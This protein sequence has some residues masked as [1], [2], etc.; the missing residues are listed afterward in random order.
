MSKPIFNLYNKDTE[1]HLLVCGDLSV[2]HASVLKDLLIQILNQSGAVSL[3]FGEVTTMDVAS[4]QIVYALK[5]EIETQGRKV[6]FE[7]PSNRNVK[8]L[9]IKTGITKIL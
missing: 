7:W 8:E 4:I 6:N 2:Q 5:K 9:L 3:G 1:S